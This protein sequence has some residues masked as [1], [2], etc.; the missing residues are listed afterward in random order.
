MPK[1]I[2]VR[3]DSRLYAPAGSR[4]RRLIYAEAR[5][6]AEESDKKVRALRLK[7]TFDTIA[8]IRLW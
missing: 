2:V 1:A 6:L 3:C 4:N 8:G 5:R 7:R